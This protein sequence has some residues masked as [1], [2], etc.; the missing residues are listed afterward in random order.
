MATCEVCGND[1]AMSF[2]VHAQGAVHVF[3]SFECAIHA[4]SPVCEHCGV[5]IS[6][7]GVE[8]DGHFFCC[9]HC[10]RGKGIDPTL[11]RDHADTGRLAQA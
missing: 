11:I 10:A 9:A 4:M 1:Y 7:H 8:A 5:K 3:D 2:E 6:G